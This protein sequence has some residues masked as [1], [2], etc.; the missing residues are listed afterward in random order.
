MP[1][2][3]PDPGARQG[4]IPEPTALIRTTAFGASCRG[5]PSLAKT[6][7]A[8]RIGRG[9]P[10]VA[11]TGVAAGDSPRGLECFLFPDLRG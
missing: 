8:L 11:G 5:F 9:G 2:P 3:G 4:L 10:M 7:A 6:G 1:P